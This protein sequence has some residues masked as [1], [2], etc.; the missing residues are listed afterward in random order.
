MKIIVTGLLLAVMQVAP[1][2]ARAQKIDS[3]GG[4]SQHSNNHTTKPAF[5]PRVVQPNESASDAK[6][7]H[8]AETS[9]DKGEINAAPKSGKDLWDK[10]Y[11]V[12]TG[13][14]VLVGILTLIA[15]GYQARE[16]ARAT[17]GMKHQAS[18]MERST[19][20]TEKSVALQE[21][22]LTQWI[23]VGSIGSRV[24]NRNGKIP[25]GTTQTPLFISFDILNPT[26]MILNLNWVIVRI[27]GER[28]P[29]QLF[30][31]AMTPGDIFPISTSVSLEGRR[32][33]EYQRHALCISIIAYV[34]FTDAFNRPRKQDFPCICTCGPPSG[35]RPSP[36]HGI[37]PDDDLTEDE[38][39][40]AKLMDQKTQR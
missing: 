40:R 19:A 16:M 27:D 15:I 10:L 1:I 26:G 6:P 11:V 2:A 5:V 30:N 29:A 35:T 7:Q 34:G 9:T 31:H 21:T 39:E 13:L 8:D 38:K 17:K 3:V 36:Y 24:Q 25:E 14:L 23:D 22:Q 12:F 28:K 33:E 18:I 32:L 4:Q 37:V 20:A